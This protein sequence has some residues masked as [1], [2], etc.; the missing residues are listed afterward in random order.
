[1]LKK[2]RESGSSGF[3]SRKRIGAD[4]SQGGDRQV[5]AP[6]RREARVGAEGV[7]PVDFITAEMPAARQET[8]TPQWDGRAQPRNAIAFGHLDLPSFFS[9]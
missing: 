7:H 6:D 2:T 8:R 3:I 1:M 9:P 4:N 5:D